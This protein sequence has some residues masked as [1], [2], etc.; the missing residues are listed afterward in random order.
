ML[1][2][3]TVAWGSKV[4]ARVTDWLRCIFDVSEYV[5]CGWSNHD[6]STTTVI[7]MVNFHNINATHHMSVYDKMNSAHV[8]GTLRIAHCW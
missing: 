4:I 1:R 5:L 6:S 8:V 7:S 3:L 2:Y